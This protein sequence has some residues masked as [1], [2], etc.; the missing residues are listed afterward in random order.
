MNHDKLKYFHKSDERQDNSKTETVSSKLIV[1]TEYIPQNY[2]N[3]KSMATNEIM[4]MDA[5]LQ[6]SPFNIRNFLA[7]KNFFQ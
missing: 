3:N 1:N 7:C 6:G 4:R 2:K 5:T